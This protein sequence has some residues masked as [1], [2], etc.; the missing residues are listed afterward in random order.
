MTFAILSALGTIPLAIDILIKIDK[1]ETKT[2]L[3]CFM[4]MEE[5]VSC[6]K[7]EDD[8]NEVIILPISLSSVGDKYRL[9]WCVPC[10]YDSA[11]FFP[12]GILFAY[13]M[14][15]SVK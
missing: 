12:F 14:P 15:I 10:R 11:V 6:P 3:S 2:L 8:F 9:D 1:G 5:N 4:R 13:L 7:D